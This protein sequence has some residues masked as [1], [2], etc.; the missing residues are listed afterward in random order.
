MKYFTALNHFTYKEIK[1]ENI[2]NFAGL[3]ALKV[4]T[5]FIVFGQ[6]KI[7]NLYS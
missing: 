4:T 5:Q 6:S 7:Q 3:V 1:K 2:K